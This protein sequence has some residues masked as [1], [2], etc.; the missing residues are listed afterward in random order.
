MFFSPR[1]STENSPHLSK[2]QTVL[3][4]AESVEDPRRIMGCAT[5]KKQVIP[6]PKKNSIAKRGQTG[7]EASHFTQALVQS[8]NTEKIEDIYEIDWD[9]ALGTGATSTVRPCRHKV[10]GEA[11]ALKTIETYRMS[12][13]IVSQLFEEVA[14]MRVLDHPNC[15][16]VIETFIDF[17]KLYIIMECCTGGELFDKLYDQPGAKFSEADARDLSLKMLSAL[18]YLHVNKII[19]RDLK[20]ENFIFTRRGPEGEV[21][22][23]DFG[24]SKAYLEGEH[25]RKVAGT[26]YYM[27]PEVL[28]GDYSEAADMWSFGVVVFMMLSGT[29]PFGGSDD[30]T[31]QMNVLR[32]KYAFKKKAWEGVSNEAKDFVAKLLVQDIPQRMT[33]EQALEHPWFHGESSG[34]KKHALSEETS[35]DHLIQ[36]MREFR[37]YCDLKRAALLAISFS[38]GDENI[39]EMRKA[40]QH[41]DSHHTGIITHDE[42]LD[43]MHKHGVMDDSECERIFSSID[44]DHTGRI[45]YNEFLAAC[46]DEKQFLDDRRVVD[47]FNKLDVDHTGKISKANLKVLFGNDC[48]DEALDRM[49]AGADFHRDGLIDLGEFRRMM[50]GETVT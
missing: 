45:K 20:L 44:Q 25:M 49:L 41:T 14:I 30:D 35:E 7:L 17:K 42:F 5:S 3:S 23:I 43:V 26:S 39:S 24:L 33:A 21:K 12:P 13:Q 15:I 38:L 29:C 48:T 28:R 40:F 50:K 8:H 32:G 31:I 1:L 10:T 46:I 4:I 6:E 47:A 36:N 34:L 18:N 22:L 19:H 9:N 27:A 11:Y 16:K 2:V 37:K